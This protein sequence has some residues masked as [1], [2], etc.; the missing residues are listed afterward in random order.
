MEEK[1]ISEEHQEKYVS[2]LARYSSFFLPEKQ[3][4]TKKI[5]LCG[6]RVQKTTDV[7]KAFCRQC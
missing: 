6:L 1:N 5:C 4:K 7:L 2:K 3:M